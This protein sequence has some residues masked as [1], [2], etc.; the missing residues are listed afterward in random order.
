MMLSSMFTITFPDSRAFI[1]SE[2]ASYRISMF[3][4]LLC[5]VEIIPNNLYDIP[6]FSF[7]N[8][9]RWFFET[10]SFSF[11]CKNLWISPILR[12]D[13]ASK[14]KS[15]S[16][17]TILLENFENLSGLLVFSNLL[18]FVDLDDNKN[19]LSWYWEILSLFEICLIERWCAN[20]KAYASYI[21][22]SLF[23]SLISYFLWDLIALFGI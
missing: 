7:K 3:S 1:Y 23:W 5:L 9:L 17:F 4:L 18:A 12:I 22:F 16:S 6:N 21:S 14:R 15:I 10:R 8:A 11:W 13:L 20:F 2:A 19:L